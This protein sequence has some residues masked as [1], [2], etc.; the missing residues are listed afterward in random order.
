MM[1]CLTGES[2]TIELNER[3]DNKK[4]KQ[5]VDEKLAVTRSGSIIE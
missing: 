1:P 3:G 2:L 4:T 5:V